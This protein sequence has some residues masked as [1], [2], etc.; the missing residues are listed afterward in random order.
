MSDCHQVLIARQAVRFRRRVTRRMVKQRLIDSRKFLRTLRLLAKEVRG[1][2]VVTIGP[3]KD[4][5]DYKMF[6][7][8]KV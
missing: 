4:I 3:H 2:R 7:K 5:K 6:S 8:S 1:H